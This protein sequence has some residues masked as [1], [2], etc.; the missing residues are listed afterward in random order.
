MFTHLYAGFG[1]QLDGNNFEGEIPASYE[2]FPE[3]V[4]L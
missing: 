1:R 3:L 4:K 2:N